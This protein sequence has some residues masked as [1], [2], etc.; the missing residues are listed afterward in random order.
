[1]VSAPPGVARAWGL[2]GSH[3]GVVFPESQVICINSDQVA[4]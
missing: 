2:I 1:V 3:S 4:P